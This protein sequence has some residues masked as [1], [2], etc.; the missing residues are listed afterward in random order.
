MD[1]SPWVTKGRTRLSA[2]HGMVHPLA[3]GGP[4]QGQVGGDTPGGR[5]SGAAAERGAWCPSRLPGSGSCGTVLVGA[6]QGGSGV[7]AGGCGA[8]G[9]RRAFPEPAW[10]SQACAAGPRPAAQALLRIKTNICAA[11]CVWWGLVF[12]SRLKIGASPTL[13]GVPAPP[14]AGLGLAWRLGLLPSS[15]LTAGDRRTKVSENDYRIKVPLQWRGGASAPGR[16]G[17]IGVGVPRGAWTPSR[18][19]FT[20]G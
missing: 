7:Q 20:R 16:P 12:F 11:C 18:A 9:D 5:G 1:Y 19:P 6:D 13:A 3:D 10:L 2:K 14:A 15:D 17:R 4:V 8:C